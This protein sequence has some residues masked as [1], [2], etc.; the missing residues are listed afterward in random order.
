MISTEVSTIPSSIS[1]S[2]S[3]SAKRT[4]L[5]DISVIFP[6]DLLNEIQLFIKERNEVFE[7]LNQEYKT[8]HVKKEFTEK[9]AKQSLFK[10]LFKKNQCCPSGGF[11]T[12]HV[13]YLNTV[14]K[15]HVDVNETIRCAL[16]RGR[17]LHEGRVH[18]FRNKLLKLDATFAQNGL[19]DND[20]IVV[21]EHLLVGGASREGGSNVGLYSH[22]PIAEKEV[23]SQRCLT[24][25]EWRR[26]TERAWAR[27]QMTIK[28]ELQSADFMPHFVLPESLKWIDNADVDYYIKLAED[29]MVLLYMLSKAHIQADVMGAIGVFAKLR[30][31]KSLTTA[32]IRQSLVLGLQWFF[33]EELQDLTNQF[34][35][36]RDV[37]NNYEAMKHSPLAEK[38]HCFMIYTLGH[39]LFDAVGM[40][41]DPAKLRGMCE[42]GKE[43]GSWR[44]ADFAY[45]CLESI[46]FICERGYQSYQ[47]GSIQPMFH[48]GRNH[49]QWLDDSAKLKRWSMCL[50]NPEPH[51]FTIFQ[52]Q[53]ELEDTI[54]KG[55][56]IVKVMATLGPREKA[57]AQ[58]VLND[59]KLLKASLITTN[60]ASKDRIEPFGVLIAGGSSVMKTVFS[61]IV[62]YHYGKS[63]GLPTSKD[64]RYVRNPLDDYWS[65]FKSYKWCVQLDD[66]AAFK[67]TAVQGVDPSVAEALQI[68]NTVAY[69]T[70]QAELCDKG[71]IPMRARLVTATTNVV[72]LNAFSYYENDLAPRRRFPVVVKLTMKP[73]YSTNGMCDTSKIPIIEQGYHDVWNIDMYRVVAANVAPAAADQ[74]VPRQQG[75]LELVQSYTCIDDFLED[76]SLMARRHFEVQTRAEKADEHMERTAV[77]TRCF[78]ITCKCL[79]LQARD[80]VDSD[81]MYA[82]DK[83]AYDNTANGWRSEETKAEDEDEVI[84]HQDQEEHICSRDVMVEIVAKCPHSWIVKHNGRIISVPDRAIFSHGKGRMVRYCP[85]IHNARAQD[86]FDPEKLI[87]ETRQVRAV[88]DEY[89][90]VI[91]RKSDKDW[92]RWAVTFPIQWLLHFALQYRILRS[93]VGVF[94]SWKWSRELC[95]LFLN[96]LVPQQ[97]AALLRLTMITADGVYSRHPRLVNIAMFC[98]VALMTYWAVNKVTNHVSRPIKNEQHNDSD[99]GSKR[100]KDRNSVSERTYEMQLGVVRPPKPHDVEYENVWSDH[101]TKAVH[102]SVS[103]M[104]ASWAG[105]SW[106]NIHKSVKWNLVVLELRVPEGE[107][108]RVIQT[109]ALCV[110]SR[111]YIVNKHSW[112]PEAHVTMIFESSGNGVSANLHFPANSVRVAEL[113]DKDLVAFEVLHAPV[114]KDLTQLFPQETFVGSVNGMYLIRHPTCVER[115]EVSNIYPQVINVGVLNNVLCYMS[116]AKR[117]T[118]KGE[119][120]SPL[121]GRVEGAV[122]LMGIHVAGH[123]RGAAAIAIDQKDI[124]LLERSMVFTR[125]STG[126]PT[127]RV[128]AHEQIVGAQH[129]KSHTNFESGCAIQVGGDPGFRPKSQSKVKSTIL[130]EALEQRGYSTENQAPNLRSWKPFSL[131]LKDLLNTNREVDLKLLHSCAEDYVQGVMENMPQGWEEDVHFYDL[132]TAING[133]DGVAYIDPIN[134]NTSAGAPCNRG[135][136]NFLIRD[137]ETGRYSLTPDMLEAVQEINTLY[138]LK[139]RATPVFMAHLKDQAIPEKKVRLEKVRVFVGGPMAWTLAVRQRLLWFIRL[140]QCNRRLFELGAGTIAQ[141][142]EWDDLYHHLTAFGT[143]RIVAGD[144]GKFDKRMGSCFILYAYWIIVQFGARAGMS[145]DELDE[146][147]CVAEDTA[148]AFTNFNG[149]LLMFMG[150]NPS[151]H[152]LTVI[153]NSLVNSLYM[154]YVY[155]QVK[156]KTHDSS[157]KKDVHL[158]TYG[159]DNIMGVRRGCDWF[160]HTVISTTLSK[161]GVEYTMADKESESVPFIHLDDASFLKRKWRW[162]EDLQKMVAPLEE[163][164]IESSLMIGVV[165]KNLTPEAH[166]IAVMQGALGEYFFHGKKVFDAKRVLFTDVITEL[167]LEDWLTRPLRTWQECVASFERSSAGYERVRD[168]NTRERVDSSG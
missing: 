85:M 52:Y 30:I 143:D 136:K 145:Q 148:F 62:F 71:R 103:D 106:D 56:S 116:R 138:G 45:L 137:D 24:E 153:V 43:R 13:L 69:V 38:L 1:A 57:M 19:C 90:D 59:L 98:S 92:C 50:G 37:L 109:R 159:D 5:N 158:Y 20:S 95:L 17:C 35:N 164:S 12:I 60:D 142:T 110:K 9:R 122:M 2:D 75:R 49:E 127:I 96:W 117:P 53:N 152:P 89:F 14:N 141:S 107:N 81:D 168:A 167:N 27:Y 146:I 7:Y 151:G 40:K 79:N 15:L 87:L 93:F 94:F 33:G 64:Y 4:D 3:K 112:N 29:C 23:V 101:D 25:E 51:G 126:G 63:L 77:C 154:R 124:T 162:D 149:D 31:T 54:E 32:Y 100:R 44:S 105:M 18:S 88:A 99:E 163:T 46:V 121:F 28:A 80:N 86:H 134:K 39:S 10:R 120:G 113:P 111:L 8:T 128:G 144:F 104:S 125:I 16:R 22:I 73:E 150:S 36:I 83:G 61:K 139:K 131:A 42:A 67:P 66:I 147:W 48:S 160:N 132:D 115:L 55:E 135:K 114:R 166:A 47:A 102:F 82:E 78:R 123:E 129:Y 68:L 84:N 41:V 58:G 119:C 161:I 91:R 26:A 130:R 97:M 76:L 65:G 21:T 72:D 70:N 6:K 74:V 133:A 157:F 156:P 155:L 140:A 165:S 118:L 34:R 108:T 11:I